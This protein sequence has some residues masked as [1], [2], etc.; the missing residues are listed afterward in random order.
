MGRHQLCVD[1]QAR[2]AQHF[3]NCVVRVGRRIIP[4]NGNE[5]TTKALNHAHLEVPSPAPSSTKGEARDARTDDGLAP[6][7]SASFLQRCAGLSLTYSAWQL[8]FTMVLHTTDVPFRSA[9]C[10]YPHD[11]FACSCLGS[12]RTGSCQCPLLLLVLM[13]YS[14]CKSIQHSPRSGGHHMALAALPSRLRSPPVFANCM[15][16]RLESPL[17]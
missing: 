15:A 17:A 7:Q 9:F 13:F 5:L 3:L 1:Q 11:S 4:P 12:F 8:A 14:R 10:A 6:R 16:Q 2:L